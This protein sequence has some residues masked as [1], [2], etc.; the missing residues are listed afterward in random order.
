MWAGDRHTQTGGLPSLKAHTAIITRRGHF[1]GKARQEGVQALRRYKTP[2][3]AQ[4]GP[5]AFR[6]S[7]Y[8]RTELRVA[9]VMAGESVVS[10]DRSSTGGPNEQVQS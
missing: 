3:F 7:G 2:R 6:F 1:V 4:P 5:S 10:C 9:Q 8:N